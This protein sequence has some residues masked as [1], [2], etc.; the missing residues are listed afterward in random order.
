MARKQEQTNQDEQG[1]EVKRSIRSFM[2]NE[3]DDGDIIEDANK[4][5]E[6]TGAKTVL[7]AVR[8]IIRKALKDERARLT[9]E[10]KAS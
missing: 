10:K 9:P 3:D 5:A 2:I 8:P 4:I 7:S 1:D 6:L